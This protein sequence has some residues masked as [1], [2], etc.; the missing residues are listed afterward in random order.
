MSED[1]LTTTGEQGMAALVRELRAR[2]IGIDTPLPWRAVPA[3]IFSAT[4]VAANG[5]RLADYLWPENAVAIVKTMN[6]CL[7]LLDALEAGKR[8]AKDLRAQL[9]AVEQDRDDRLAQVLYTREE[10]DTN[11][12]LHVAAEQRVAEERAL[13]HRIADAKDSMSWWADLDRHL[14][15]LRAPEGAQP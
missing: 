9:A 6:A 12:R 13:L 8:E 5:A 4:I 1:R 11:A 15:G 7:P 2:V 10:R 14:N 3:R